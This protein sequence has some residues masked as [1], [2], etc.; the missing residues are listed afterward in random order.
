MG[1]DTRQRGLRF[2]LL[3]VPLLLPSLAVAQTGTVTGKV[4]DAAGGAPLEAARVVLAGTTRIA[5]TN[6]EGVYLFRAVAPG[7]YQLRALAL[8]YRPVTDT[9]SVTEG[10]AA[11]ADFAM[12]AAPVQLDE[13]VATATGEQRKLEIGN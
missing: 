13:I 8:G 6:R 12:N 4:T 7:T 1:P 9:V 5:T 10:A 2:R 3:F 11:T